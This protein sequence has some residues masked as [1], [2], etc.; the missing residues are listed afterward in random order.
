MMNNQTVRSVAIIGAG[1]AGLTTARSLL[2][3]GI[4]CTLFESSTE[5]GGVW[6]DGYLNFGAQV[7]R[8]LYKFPDWP[9]PPD[10]PDF[11]PGPMIQ[12]Y[13]R[14]FAEQ[15]GITS[16]I[17]F[18]AR[19]IRLAEAESPHS[20]WFVEFE[21]D[22]EAHGMIFDRVVICTG[23]YSQTPHVPE[24][25]G[26]D[27]FSGEVFHNSRLK[28]PDQLEGKRVAIIGYGKGA[29]DAAV[30]SAR[31]AQRTHLVFR[32][33]HWPIPQKLA[34]LLPFKWGLLNRLCS[35]LLPPYQQVTPVERMMQGIGKPL[36][37]FYWRIVET[38][39][40]FQ[41][42]LGSRFGTRVS[43]VPKQPVE[44]DA[45]GESTQVPKPKFFRLAR[46]GK[47]D[48]HRTGIERFD[49]N[50]LRLANGEILDVDTVIFATGWESDF[51]FLSTETWNR[52][53]PTDDG[54]YLY[55]H[56]LHPNVSGLCFVGRA[57]SISSILT[58]SLQARWLAD[59]FT[60][61]ILLP[62]AEHFPYEP[63]DYAAVVSPR[64][65]GI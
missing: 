52:L 7:Q 37:W 44:I 53:D 59:V 29:S 17:R 20:G 25:P 56:I 22:G 35:T 16:K 33:A 55:R 57:A 8:E 32:E 13:L 61:R 46:D 10:T 64:N 19:V 23:L 50:G 43:L 5:L 63:G 62:P 60:G 15:F 27:Q 45:F 6:S 38:L 11:T 51:S 58:Y 24:F 54:F 1:V 18:D 14:N 12:Q 42:G 39:F 65:Q 30:E 31:L 49:S 9:F 40:Y 21:S 4:D 41:Y 3:E 36:A 34:G 48:L 28:T 2:A 26:R 47:I